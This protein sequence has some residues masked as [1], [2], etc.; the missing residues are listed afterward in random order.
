MQRADRGQRSSNSNGTCI[1]TGYGT[2]ATG[3]P[4]RGTRPGRAS[5][6]EAKPGLR[7]VCAIGDTARQREREVLQLVAAGQTDGQIAQHLFISKKGAS[8]HVANIK[9]KLGARSRVEI[10]TDALAFGLV[11]ARSAQDR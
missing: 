5:E 9:S 6:A 2:N 11:E 8:F 1:P 10:A 3:T 4:L 7:V